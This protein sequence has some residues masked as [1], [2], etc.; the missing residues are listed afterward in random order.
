MGVEDIL[1]QGLN[2]STLI[3]HQRVYI[4]DL[5]SDTAIAVTFNDLKELI[6]E[7]E[8]I[9]FDRFGF[10]SP[11]TKLIVESIQVETVSKSTQTTLKQSTL[12][13]KQ[14]S[15]LAERHAVMYGNKHDVCF[16]DRKQIPINLEINGHAIIIEKTM[17]LIHI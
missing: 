4:R 12:G 10:T 14:I 5:G 2:I 15:T 9:H 13:T 11:E 7:F 17:Y 16:Y 8:I 1:A 6:K 3:H